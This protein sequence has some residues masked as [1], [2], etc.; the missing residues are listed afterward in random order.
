MRRVVGQI[1]PPTDRDQLEPSGFR[2][3][4]LGIRLQKPGLS[5]RDMA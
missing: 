4:G 1:D 3:V 2:R 5:G